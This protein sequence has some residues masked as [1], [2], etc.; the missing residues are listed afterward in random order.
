MFEMNTPI[1][2]V[3]VTMLVYGINFIFILAVIFFER[4]TSTATLAWIMVL[5]FIPVLGFILY[6][7]FNQNLTRIKINKLYDDEKSVLRG[8]LDYQIKEVESGHLKPSNISSDKWRELIVLNQ[9]YGKA[10]YTDANDVE[11]IT[12]GN[13]LFEHMIEDIS[14]A[15][16]SISAEY[17]IIKNDKIGKRFISELTKKAAEG[18]EV[19]LLIDSLGSRNIN[20]TVLKKYLAAGGKVAYFFP[21]RLA[22]LGVK[23]GLNLNYRNHRKILIID[24]AIGYTGGYNI[25]NEYCDMVPKFGHWRDSHVRIRG[26]GV[27]ELNARFILDWRFVTKEKLDL[28]EADRINTEAAGNMGLQIVS[29]GPEAHKQEIKRGFMKI[30]TTA[31]ESVYIQSPY[32][33]PDA[34][35]LESC[36]MAAQSGVKVNIMIPK[37]PDHIFVYWATYSYVGELLRDGCRVFIYDGGFMHAK[38]IFADGEVT[39]IGSCNFDIRSFKLNFE[40][41]A[42]IFDKS[43]TKSM[44]RSFE[45]DIKNSHELTLEAYN[46]RSLFI[47][48]KES[49]SRLLTEIL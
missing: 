37:M 13:E 8:Y 16:A 44:E 33:V 15:K 10:I 6:L 11:L 4:K 31:R 40:T 12:D 2:P 25:A 3:S 47:R 23:I 32:F 28:L 34:P 17:F 21:P 45:E 46:N 18:L 41:N 38:A 49:V 7:V 26:I 39:S 48:F 20:N 1:G 43:F 19:R 22:K 27:N 24:N 29:C 35:I 42:V 9:V 36:K 30:I 14:N 5:A